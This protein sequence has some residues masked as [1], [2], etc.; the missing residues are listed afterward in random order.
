MDWVG[1]TECVQLKGQ[2][3]RQLSGFGVSLWFVHISCW[4]L[5]IFCSLPGPMDGLWMVQAVCDGLDWV[6]PVLSA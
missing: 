1:V 4:P 5:L 2:G 6:L 3:R